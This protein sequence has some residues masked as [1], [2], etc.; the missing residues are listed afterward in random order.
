MAEIPVRFSHLLGYSGPG[1]IVRGPDAL[2]VVQDTSTWIDKAGNTGAV[3]LLYVDRVVYALGIHPKKLRTPPAAKK[4]QRGGVDGVCIPATRFPKWM[5]CPKCGRLYP[6]GAWRA[7][8]A[9]TPKCTDPAGNNARN[10]KGTPLEQ[11]QYVMVHPYGYLA[12]LPWRFLAHKS[13]DGHCRAQDKLVLETNTESNKRYLK[14]EICLSQSIFNDKAPQS[15]GTANEQPWLYDSPVPEDIRNDNQAKIIKIN[16]SRCYSPEIASAL[17]IPP[18]SHLKRGTL[19]D[20]LYRSADDR[21]KLAR[22]DGMNPLQRKSA[23]RGFTGKYNCSTADIEEAL[24]DIE[25]GYPYYGK[26]FA[27]SQLSEDEYNAL[28][29]STIISLSGDEDFITRHYSAQ[30]RELVASTVSRPAVHARAKAVQHLVKVDRIKEVRVFKGF[31]RENGE[32]VVSPDISGRAD[33]LPAIELYGEGIFF[34]LDTDELNTWERNGQVKKRFSAI[35]QRFVAIRRKEPV[36]LTARFLLLHTLSHLIIRQLE[37]VGG[38]PAASLTERLFCNDSLNNPMAGIL[39]Y[40]TSPDKAGTLGGLAELAEPERFLHILSQALDNAMWCSS[41]P[42]CREHEGQGTGGLNLAA[43]HACALVPD[44]ACAYGNVLL[45][46][47]LVKGDRSQNVPSLF[48]T[49]R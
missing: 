1:A 40:T 34:T 7:Q 43:C 5:I 38:Y 33:W 39:I 27:D 3:E 44:T 9:D 23:L 20:R 35:E 47:V 8:Q 22:L 11:V 2:M 14:C 30:W 26:D 15:F 36:A 16:D 46:R 49:T 17:V 32:N 37:A 19:V 13:G 10:C 12:D 25:N 48:D 28:L 6:P 41:D 31:R 42:V 21:E 18:E 29:D 24:A 4:K 45:D